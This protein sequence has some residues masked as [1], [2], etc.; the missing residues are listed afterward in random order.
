MSLVDNEQTKLLANALAVSAALHYGRTHSER[1]EIMSNQEF[2]IWF[3][4]LGLPAITAIGGYV[5]VR[6]HE[7]SLKHKSIPACFTKPVT[8]RLR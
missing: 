7:R 3:W 2:M 4:A 8:N 6:L 5:A 1:P